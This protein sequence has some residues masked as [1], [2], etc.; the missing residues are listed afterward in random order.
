MSVE[1]LMAIISRG[2][3]PGYVAAFLLAGAILDSAWG[4]YVRYHG[5]HMSS[6]SKGSSR[7]ASRSNRAL[8]T[9]AKLPPI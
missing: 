1:V 3:G 7:S 2:S 9:D 8:V 5:C 4:L 6:D